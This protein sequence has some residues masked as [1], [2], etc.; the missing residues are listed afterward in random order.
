MRIDWQTW[1]N[2]A[3]VVLGLVITGLILPVLKHLRRIRFNELKHVED[4]LESIET[5]LD[6]HINW[7]LNHRD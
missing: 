4:R 6:T 7:H 2:T 5:K 3:S 1:I